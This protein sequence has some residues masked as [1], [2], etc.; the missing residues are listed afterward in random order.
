[1]ITFMVGGNDF[2]VDMCFYK[3][4]EVI[5]E[6]HKKDLIKVLRLLRDNLP[7]TIVSV[8]LAPRKY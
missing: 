3:K 6:N 5:V 7:R 1:M 4:P 2:C 8:I